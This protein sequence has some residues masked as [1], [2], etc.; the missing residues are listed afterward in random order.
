MRT[1]VARN[2]WA[3]GPVVTKGCRE[4]QLATVLV[5]E[6]QGSPALHSLAH[7]GGANSACPP[8]R[9]GATMEGHRPRGC[10]FRCRYCA[11]P[12]MARTLVGCAPREVSAMGEA[13]ACSWRR[14]PA[15]FNGSERLRVCHAAPPCPRRLGPAAGMGLASVL[16]CAQ[17]GRPALADL[18]GR[19]EGVARRGAEAARRLCGPR[20]FCA[21]ARPRGTGG[22]LEDQ[23][24]A[25]PYRR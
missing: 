19:T 15:R 14:L 4:I 21:G 2:L 10:C 3:V 6:S 16:A 25:C 7:L 5:A 18:V 17:P 1:P 20:G 12:R 23:P 8:R 11:G 13:L 24:L 22:R 9:D